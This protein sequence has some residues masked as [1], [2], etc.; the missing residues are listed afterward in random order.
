MLQE[1][2]SAGSMKKTFPRVGGSQFRVGGQVSRQRIHVL[3]PSLGP[4]SWLPPLATR[5]KVSKSTPSYMGRRSFP[6]ELLAEASK[7]E[8]STC[9]KGS[10]FLLVSCSS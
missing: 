8:R 6:S 3:P 4:T 1:R 9:P 7:A 2:N 10:C 5:A